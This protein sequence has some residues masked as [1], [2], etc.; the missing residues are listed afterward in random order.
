MKLLSEIQKKLKAPKNQFNS[1]GKYKYR[2][3]EDIL[4]GIK[5]LLNG[6]S[7]RLEDEI[8]MIG[9]RYYV[10]A[11]ATLSDGT[12]TVSASAFAR[13]PENKKGM[14]ESQITGTASSYAR[15]YALNGL[16]C[17]DDTKDAD[18]DE[19]TTQQ[20]NTP[21]DTPEPNGEVMDKLRILL[22]ENTDGRA[23]SGIKLKN[24]LWTRFKKYPQNDQ[25][26]QKTATWLIEKNM[27]NSVLEAA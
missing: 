21:N 2:S 12:E 5:P 17:I 4:E 24:L 6:G 1:F 8:V 20:A 19:H 27:I 22:E 16:F 14:D 10:K 11:T 23:V 25:E 13:E 18:T 7:L 9:S 26:A 3:C 15:K